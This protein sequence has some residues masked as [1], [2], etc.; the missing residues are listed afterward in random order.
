[1]SSGRGHVGQ[2]AKFVVI[3]PQG[4]RPEQPG[5]ETASVA[6]HRVGEP[7]APS[8]Q[9]VFQAL[10]GVFRVMQQPVRHGDGHDAVVR[11]IV[12]VGQKQKIVV[13]GVVEFERRSDDVPCDRS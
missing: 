2:G 10:V 3:D 6:P 4:V 9:A 8:E 11:E 7:P 12:I 13:L 5:M 1:M